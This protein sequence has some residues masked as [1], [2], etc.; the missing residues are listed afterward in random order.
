MPKKKLPP[1]LAW[2]HGRTMHHMDKGKPIGK[3]MSLAGK[4]YRQGGMA[5]EGRQAIGSMS[6][7]SRNALDA[8]LSKAGGSRQP[9]KAGGG[10]KPGGRGRGR[11][12]SKDPL[13]AALS[14]LG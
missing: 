10:Q 13:A 7:G 8:A 5:Q 3:A 11:G 14:R 1:V 12:S 6:R 4:D 9:K 2:I